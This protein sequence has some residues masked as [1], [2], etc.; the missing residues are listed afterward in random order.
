AFTLVALNGFAQPYPVPGFD[1][2]FHNH[3]YHW[4]YSAADRKARKMSKLVKQEALDSARAN[5]R[6]LKANTLVVRLRTGSSKIKALEKLIANPNTDSKYIQ[7]YE[8]M[9]EKEKTRTR[10]ENR[11]I[12]E[13]FKSQYSFSNAV[14][15]M[16]DTAIVRL[17]SGTTQGIFLNE[18]MEIDPSIGL[19]G[20]YF[21]CYYGENSSDLYTNIE[22]ITIVDKNLT[23][24]KYPFPSFVGVTGI[25]RFYNQLFNKDTDKEYFEK[26]VA[27]LQKRMDVNDNDD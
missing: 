7:R 3:M 23:P 13:A 19:K 10:D 6:Y 17:K 21:V 14:Y 22:G 16:P 5:I 15:F 12:M 24:L 27:K 20:N 2:G 26:L 9:I 18:Q 1:Y 11:F 25:R 4:H 8:S